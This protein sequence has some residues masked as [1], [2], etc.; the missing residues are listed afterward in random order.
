MTDN[1]PKLHEKDKERQ[2][3]QRKKQNRTKSST[4]PT[5]AALPD[6]GR[7]RCLFVESYLELNGSLKVN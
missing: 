5:Q 3:H 6:S 2:N 4:F 7:L 1:L